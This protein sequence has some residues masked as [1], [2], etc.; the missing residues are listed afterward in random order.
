[1]SCPTFPQCV[2][3][4]RLLV[5]DMAILQVPYVLR[6]VQLLALTENE[7]K[8]TVEVLGKIESGGY[9]E[10]TKVLASKTSQKY[11]ARN[12]MEISSSGGENTTSGDKAMSSWISLSTLTKKAGEKKAAT[13]DANSAETSQP[14]LKGLSSRRSDLG[15]TP[16]T[17]PQRRAKW[18][19]R[20]AR[21]PC[22]H[23]HPRGPS[24]TRGEQCGWEIVGVGGSF[25]F[26]R[27]QLGS[28]GFDDIE[29]S[30]STKDIER[31]ILPADKEKVDQFTTDEL[32]T[33]SFHALGQKLAIDEFKSSDDFK[34][35]VT[36]FAATYFGERFKFCKRQLLHHHAN[37]SVDLEGMEMDI[38]LAKEEEESKVGDKEEDNEGEVN[39]TP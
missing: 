32:V 23:P 22:R 34:D 1:M 6:R 33:K 18:M 15:M 20:R 37:L 10:V 14:P 26:A 7:A 29:C 30:Y 2:A 19:T 36:D 9:F 24:P 39:P 4:C 5:G 13:K 25:H 16:T 38:N 17:P 31:R 35:A 21:S 12:R 11:F 27:Q 8:R 3:I 28:R